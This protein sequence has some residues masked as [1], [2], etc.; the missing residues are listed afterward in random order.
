M[1]FF[2]SEKEVKSKDRWGDDV[3][4][5]VT[6][7]NTKN[8][9]KVI[10]GFVIF[11]LILM[12]V[13]IVQTGKVQVVTR[14]GK[15]VRTNGEG[16]ALHIPFIERTKSIDTTVRRESADAV[17]ATSNLQQ[18]TVSAAV[19]YR[20]T[21]DNAIK[22]YQNFTKKDF[23]QIIVQPKIQDSIKQITPEYT[24]ETL[25][26]K[27]PEVAEKIKAVL[28]KSLGEYGISVVDVSI[29][30]YAFSAE[31][32]QAVA[33]KSVIEQQIEAAKLTATKN[34]EEGKAAVIA[35]QKAA[36]VRS[37]ESQQSATNLEFYKL[38]IQDRAVAKWNGVS[39]LYVGSDAPILTVPVK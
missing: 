17:V 12:A 37:I 2:Y 23:V 24:A 11:F 3:T 5:N 13:D 18:V 30:N 16:L 35:A 19:N 4:R 21:R 20:I 36:E 34:E 29:A 25:V 14:F 31:Y 7:L 9:M 28:D 38:Q 1:G 15:V 10:I 33:S 6:V 22:Q 8:I 32:T 26:T 39:P 27:R